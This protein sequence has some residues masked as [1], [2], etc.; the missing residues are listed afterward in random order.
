ME[1]SIL[2]RK[3][4]REKA[5][6]QKAEK[7]LEDKSRELYL[8][9]QTLQ[10]SHE[11]LDT[12]LKEVK[13]QQRQL[14]QS[15]KVASLGTM[16]AGVAHEINNPLAFIFSNVNS[17]SYAI[18]QFSEYHKHVVGLVS[19]QS[20]EI[21]EQR[22]RALGKYIADVDL[23]FLFKDC[24]DLLV[25]T[26]DGVERVKA[27][28]AGLQAFARSD[29]GGTESVDIIECLTNTLKLA[30]NQIKFSMKV[31]ED[32][33]EVPRVRGFP[34]KLSQVFLNLI[35]NASHATENGVL[36]IATR[37]LGDVVSIS[38]T[39]NG[40]GMTEETLNSVFTPFSTTKPVGKG[41]G[42]GL[43]ISHGIV[44]ELNGEIT[45]TSEVGVGTCFTIMLAGEVCAKQAA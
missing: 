37:D 18:D 26:T 31:Q 38:F 23:E 45:V 20:T 3:L 28:V 41:T 24:E 33:S 32:Y 13:S 15:E 2:Q 30:N 14:V 11:Q 21:R 34:G 42:L 40:C 29:A 43:S 6:R 10:K 22:L 5:R 1:I 8:S 12:A 16:S 44:A 17:L 7:L 9:Y 35:V 36:K 19:E 4:K 27:I 39:D 25:E